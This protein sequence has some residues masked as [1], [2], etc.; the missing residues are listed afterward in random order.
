MVPV[1]PQHALVNEL[2]VVTGWS[3][4]ARMFRSRPHRV[5]LLLLAITIMA[6][7]DLALTLNYITSIGMV[8][9]NPVAR[10]VMSLGSTGAVVIW[11]VALTAFTVGVL[12]VLRKRGIAEV[13]TWACATVMVLLS[14]HWLNF[15]N[16][17]QTMGSEY[18]VLALEAPHEGWTV[19]D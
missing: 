9:L 14:M 16:E 1:A 19:I 10:A 6:A 15:I 5:G 13:A 8:E 17:V 18:L 4:V 2:P 3:G 12:F 7:A 11:K